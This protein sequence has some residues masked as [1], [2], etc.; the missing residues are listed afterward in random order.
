MIDLETIKE[1]FATHRSGRFR[2]ERQVGQGGMGTVFFAIDTQFDLPVAIK[3]INP[4]QLA[5]DQVISRFKK[6]ARILRRIRH[7]SIVEV[8]D[9]DEIDGL[10]YIVLEWVDGGNLWNYVVKN[11]A[12]APDVAVNMMILVCAG[13]EATHA[14]KVIHR[15]VKPE[16]ILLT[17]DGFPKVTDFGIAR[18]DDARTHHTRDGVGMGSLGYMAPEQIDRAATVDERAD[19][20]ALGVTLWAIMRGQEPPAGFFFAPAIEDRPELMVGIP[21]S[22]REIITKATMLRP[23]TRY[24]SVRELREAL[25]SALSELPKSSQTLL[26]GGEGDPLRILPPNIGFAQTDEFDGFDDEEHLRLVRKA[27]RGAIAKFTAVVATLFL[28]IA[29]VVV[30]FL[31]E[32]VNVPLPKPFEA[33]RSPQA[34][35]EGDDMGLPV[36]STPEFPK[37]TFDQR[38]LEQEEARRSRFEIELS[39]T[40]RLQGST[41]PRL[42]KTEKPKQVEPP[43]KVEE[44]KVEVVETVH[45]GF[46]AP[47]GDAVKAWLV[48]SSGR[49]RLPCNVPA[50]TYK[51]VAKFGSSETEQAGPSLVVRSGESP[52]V[53][54][55]SSFELCKVK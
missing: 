6:E 8:Y 42:K 55:N 34:L 13:I 44:P 24:G 28:A 46:S 35:E 9:L 37:P 54:C 11:G 25:Q 41:T 22:L 2:I 43:P 3:I 15:D 26:F 17:K 18:M 12:L 16:N 1:A 32:S 48:G 52:R 10:S 19:V 4:D 30:Y 29:G 40:P 21:A 38:A 27:R 14:K 31:S 7:P 5:S 45:V 23:E 53:N 47:E 36:L 51:V 20:H 50:G 33:L 39:A 49:H